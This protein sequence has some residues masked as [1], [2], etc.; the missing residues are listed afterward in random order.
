M[1]RDRVAGAISVELLR[2]RVARAPTRGLR[3]GYIK[4]PLG[5]VRRASDD[6]AKALFFFLPFSC[7]QARPHLR[8]PRSTRA[9]NSCTTH[10]TRQQARFPPLFFLLTL[11]LSRPSWT[12]SGLAASPGRQ[13]SCVTSWPRMADARDRHSFKKY[14][15]EFRWGEFLRHAR[16]AAGNVA[17]CSGTVYAA[18]QN[19]ESGA[20]NKREQQ[21]SLCIAENKSNF[22]PHCSVAPDAE[23]ERP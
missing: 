19:S 14:F 3:F 5:L 1:L 16:F 6:T 12:E 9:Y 17:R 15:P 18:K 23:G 8:L 13:R 4:V 2:E 20:G 22:G 11:C 21:G 7:F 10:E